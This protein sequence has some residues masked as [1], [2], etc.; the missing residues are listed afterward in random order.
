[1]THR[2]V[3]YGWWIVAASFSILLVTVGVGLYAPPI[4]LVP[5]QDHFGWSRAA[6]A[7]GSAVAALTVGAVSPLVGISIDRY[8]SRK[9]MT[10]G[11]LVMG[12]AF[13]LFGAIQSLW[14]LY[15]L[16]VIAAIGIASVAWLPNQTLISN[17]FDRIRGRAM[18][19]ALAGIGFGGLAMPPLADFLITEFGWRIAFAALGSLVLLIV[20]TVTLALVRSKPEDMGLLPD[21]EPRVSEGPSRRSHPRGPGKKR[22]ATG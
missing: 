20:V 17:W 15:A 2:E 4:F 19:I 16:N 11:A 18:G 8:G 5:L 10:A 1:M 12:S 14:Q 3:Y 9:V 7:G 6:I 22:E 21:G 13:C